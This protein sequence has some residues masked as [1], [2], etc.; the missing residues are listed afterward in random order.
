MIAAA[1][2]LLHELP[3]RPTAPLAIVFGG[4]L[5]AGVHAG[6]DVRRRRI[7]LH[8]SLAA[9]QTEFRRILVHELFHLVWVRLGNPTRLSYEELLRNE[10]ERGARGELGWSA[11]WRK[12]R[13]DTGD[14]EHRSRSWRF[15]A[16]ESFCDTAA[17]RWSGL[18]NHDEFTLAA[19][20]RN[21][22]RRWFDRICTGGL[23]L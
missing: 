23:P 6:T 9:D 18:P 20:H 7:V 8:Q 11:E 1:R 5:P 21:R 4:D 3:L 17:W 10:L 15:Y 16:C 2:Q 12:Q 14:R 19:V 13:L 22:R